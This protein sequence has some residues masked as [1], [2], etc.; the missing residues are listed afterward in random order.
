MS[1]E[2]FHNTP[3]HKSVLSRSRWGIWALLGILV[4]SLGAFLLAPWSLQDKTLAALHGLCAQQPTHSFW[5]GETRLP[6]DARMTGIYGAFAVVSIYLLARGRLYRIGV[7]PVSIIIGLGL[8][9]VAMGIDGVNSTLND[10]GLPY[11]YEPNNHL[12]FF[13]GALTGTTLA[14]F[15]WLLAAS[16]LWKNDVVSA[17]PIITSWKEF[18]PISIMVSM[19]WAIV[20]L[21]WEPLFAPL[22]LIQ[23]LTAVTVVAVMALVL[24]TMIARRFQR[25][26]RPSD[27][28]GAAAAAIVAAYLFMSMFAGARFMLEATAT[29]V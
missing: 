5:I 3:E 28:A 23:V 8:F 15:L 14:I 21:R 18:L 26:S 4:V 24:I 22:A 20:Q 7:P 27:V 12:R 2:Q 6:F 17:K 19:L 16:S 1:T 25:A 29:S 9:I 13:T 10:I 11:A